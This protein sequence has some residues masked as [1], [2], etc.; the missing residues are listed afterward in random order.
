[1]RN[2]KHMNYILGDFN[3]HL[4]NGL[5]FC[6]KAY[7]L[8]EEIR[9]APN[10]IEKLRLRKD[11]QEKKLVEELLPIA[12]YIQAKCSAGRQIKVRWIDGKQNYD[13]RLLFAGVLVEKRL[14]PKRQYVE[15]TTAVHENDH[16]S[17]RLMNEQ[18]HTFGV[19][20][21]RKDPHT[22]KYVSLPH[23]YTNYERS[24]DLAKKILERIKAKNKIEYPKRTTLIIQCFLD[25]LLWEN[26]W[27]YAIQMV[28][29]S[30]VVHRFQEIF[31]FDSNDHYSA[32]M[33]GNRGKGTKKLSR[34]IKSSER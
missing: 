18:G 33:H 28:K 22:E 17:R 20:G 23:V 29:R 34:T 4:M 6:K 11:R 14:V 2:K 15:V 32:S 21:V 16:I 9:R 25:T 13:A 30:G 1:M 3:N 27:E 31:L 19:K 8:F 5:D 7:G 24:E 26:E 12:R 10:G